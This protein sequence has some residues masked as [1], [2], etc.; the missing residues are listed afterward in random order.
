[1]RLSS[2]TASY[3]EEVWWDHP[4]RRAFVRLLEKIKVINHPK[5]LTMYELVVAGIWNGTDF[6]DCVKKITDEA[7]MGTV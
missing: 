1:M 6:D 5:G 3:L 7:R 4:Q 2:Q